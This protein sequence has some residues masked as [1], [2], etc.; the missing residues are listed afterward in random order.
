MKAGDYLTDIQ[1]SKPDSKFVALF[2][3]SR[4]LNC[5]IAA[6]GAFAGGYVSTHHL[7]YFLPQIILASA[8]AA[9][10]TAGGN[11]VNDYFDLE[12]DRINKP[13]RPLPSGAL[14]RDA[15]LSFAILAF[16]A[17][18]AL[19]IFV[20]WTCAA[21][22]AVNI[23]LLSIYNKYLK[24]RGLA[25]NICV[26]YL[27]GSVFLFGGAAVGNIRFSGILAA[28]AALSN[29]G[30]EVI[31]DMEDVKGDVGKRTTLPMKIGIGNAGALA[32]FATLAAV[33]LSPTPYF[34]RNF[35]A[36]YMLCI[37]PADAL[38]LY[39]LWLALGKE[40]YA[41]AQRMMKLAMLVAVAAFVIGRMGSSIY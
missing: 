15:A 30:R 29:F 8:A 4:P 17:A 22:C 41:K 16:G 11:A 24:R 6:L 39:S 3:L 5:A 21:I 20:N 33:A 34:L 12:I 26:A 1:I 23:A 27:V 7:A 18:L 25:G 13:R 2:R 36:V 31:K 35:N 38:F 32:A 28:M 40:Q 10:A 19:A 37:V 9:L 14:S